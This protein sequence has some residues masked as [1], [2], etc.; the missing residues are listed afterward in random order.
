VKRAMRSKDPAEVASG[1]RAGQVGVGGGDD[2]NVHVMAI[3]GP[4]RRD[5]T[6]LQYAKAAV[7]DS[8]QR[9]MNVYP[10]GRRP[11]NSASSKALK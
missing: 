11:P 3:G 5:L 4:K 7:I 8:R 6:I 2:A 9:V 1:D 10:A